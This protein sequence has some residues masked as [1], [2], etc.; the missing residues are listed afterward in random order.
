MN[1][2]DSIFEPT[3][4]YHWRFPG[5]C[6]LEFERCP[7]SLVTGAVMVDVLR[8]FSLPTR[9][10]PQGPQVMTVEQVKFT[11]GDHA[12][13]SPEVDRRVKRYDWF[14]PWSATKDN[15][16]FWTSPFPAALRM[17]VAIGCGP[18]IVCHAETPIRQ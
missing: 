3:S 8:L 5:T 15:L 17:M 14:N 10:Q 4:Y 12:L 16:A 18:A 11:A 13:H 1:R 7:F 6:Q 2:K 9:A